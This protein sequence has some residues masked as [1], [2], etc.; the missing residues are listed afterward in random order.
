M[1]TDGALSLWEGHLAIAGG[2]K[3]RFVLDYS[4]AREKNRVGRPAEFP[5]IW[6]EFEEFR[7]KMRNREKAQDL[8]A[9]I[10]P[11]EPEGAF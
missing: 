5:P 3:M 4:R 7:D 6:A 2:R 8:L 10:S 9:E 11:F 1:R